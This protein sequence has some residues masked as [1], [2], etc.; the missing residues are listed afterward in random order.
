MS[1]IEKITRRVLFSVFKFYFFIQLK[2]SCS[3]IIYIKKTA[4]DVTGMIVMLTVPIN[5]LLFIE[6]NR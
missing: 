2:P 5:N 6:N 3:P 1:L 4:L